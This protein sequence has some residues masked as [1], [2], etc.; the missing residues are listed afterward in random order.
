MLILDI[1]ISL[2]PI[3]LFSVL[4]AFL[5][6]YRL[7]SYRRILLY[8]GSGLVVA[9]L[10]LIVNYSLLNYVS[11]ADSVLI[12]YIAPFFE[13]ALKVIIP[14]ILIR[15]NKIGF[16]I[17]AA[18]AGFS[19]GCGFAIFENIYYLS[20]IHDSGIY[21]W[22]VRG[23]GTAIM[24]GGTTAVFCMI[25]IMLMSKSN[26]VKVSRFMPGY[27]VA[28][29]IHFAFNSFS[30]D[31]LYK[32]LSQVIVLPAIISFVFTESE[33]GLKKW[34]QTGF[35][36][37]VQLLD[38]LKSG[39]FIDSKTGQYMTRFS[40][41]FAPEIVLDLHC[42]LRVYLELAIRSKGILMMREAGFNEPVEQDIE[43]KFK[44]LEYLEKSIGKSG[45]KVVSPLLNQSVKELWQIYFL[46]ENQEKHA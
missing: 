7:M 6:S 21:F 14:I 30:I 44:E 18:I 34:L 41:S 2:V 22:I 35:D 28:A 8:I 23:F 29:A 3:V 19:V 16:T 40:S 10:A 32:V 20:Y 15:R 38:N 4:L 13:E 25:S 42:Y 1:L 33:K 37:N 45:Q 11:I 39:K 26:K 17:D 46:A 24:H 5:D 12:K 31:P 9:L 27:V 36:T 43:D